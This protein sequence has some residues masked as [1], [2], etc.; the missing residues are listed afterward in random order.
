MPIRILHF[1]DIHFGQGKTN[2][3]EPHDD[4]REEV[5][6][7]LRRVQADGLIG[8]KADLVLVTGDIAQKGTEAEFKRASGWLHEV[9]EIACT[10][11][12]LIRTVP[13]NHDVNLTQ[14][15]ATG[16]L[17]QNAL[18]AETDLERTYNYLAAAGGQAHNPLA[19]KLDDYQSFAFAHGSDFPTF[20]QPFTI[21]KLDLPGGR[22]LRIIG[23]CTVLVSD[24]TDDKGRM[25][26]GRNQYAISR[27]AGY[28]DIYMMHHPTEWLKDRH[29]AEIYLRSR[30][31]ILMTGHEHWP[32][33]SAIERDNGFQQV[34]LAAGALNPPGNEDGYGYT[35][36]W[37]ELDWVQDA[38]DAVLSITVYPR[39]WNKNATAFGAD[40]ER[41]NGRDSRA[42]T[43]ACG[44]RLPQ[45]TPPVADPV[46]VPDEPL[47]VAPA[48]VI[49]TLT[50][51]DVVPDVADSEAF[52]R[53][54]HLFWQHL[55]KQQRVDTLIR[56]GLL[57]EHARSRLPSGFERMAFEAASDQG[58][59]HLLWEETMP[60]I[61]QEERTDNPFPGGV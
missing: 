50:E 52:E 25:I 12:A 23:L 54:R 18:R 41:L 30:A 31:R 49:L 34:E 9:R 44:T 35:F 20:S 56:L 46:V 6:T 26:L 57:T 19:G 3:W 59:L 28:E 51:T 29:D 45:P 39:K 2:G 24:L 61:P 11:M 5:L 8:G 15:D 27:D 17:T 37:I 4:V 13:G 55:S 14:L 60:Q 32:Q 38:A 16:H 58:K 53:L 21:T 36:N 22:G 7:D 1:S 48:E 42:V 33:I 10:D 47:S 43:L 40:Y